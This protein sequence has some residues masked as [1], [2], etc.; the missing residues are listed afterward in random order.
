MEP[1]GQD[2]T[3][4]RAQARIRKQLALL[5]TQE[6]RRLLYRSGDES[7]AVLRYLQRSVAARPQALRQ[8]IR[9]IYLAVQCQDSPQLCGAVTDL[10]LV[11]KTRGTTL[12]RRIIDQIEPLLQ[13]EQHE[14]FRT[15]LDRRDPQ[16]L[17]QLPIDESVLCNSGYFLRMP[18]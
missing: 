3:N 7:T 8:H 14:R 2:D 5:N 16:A 13:P 12:Q 17:A 4:P 18:A 11:L 15:A 10:M 9:R 1:F 6:D